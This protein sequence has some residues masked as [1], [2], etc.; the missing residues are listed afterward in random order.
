MNLTKKLASALVAVAMTLTCLPALAE[1][2]TVTRAQ[3]VNSF[4]EAVGVE[5]LTPVG[6]SP[7]SFNDWDE[8]PEE[9]RANM[10]LAVESGLILGCDGKLSPNAELTRL[11]AVI[12]L[13]RCL[14]ELTEIRETVAFTDVPDWAE[15]E[16]ARLYR[17]GIVNGY[18]EGLMGSYDLINGEQLKL[19]TDRAGSAAYGNVSLKDDFYAA[20]NRDYFATTRIGEGRPKLSI[21]SVRGDE[22]SDW[23]VTRS[24]ELLERLNAG[25]E[26]KPVEER[27][28]RFY[29]LALKT[30]EEAEPLAPLNKYFE[31]IDACSGVLDFGNVNGVIIRDLSVPVLFG[32]TLP[33]RFDHD[34]YI[35]ALGGIYID[36]LDTG[37][38]RSYWAEDADGVEAAYAEYTGR[39]LNLVGVRDS[40]ALA[41]AIAA[42]QR[43]VALA[44]KSMAQSMSDEDE[45]LQL[46]F[47]WNELCSMY[48]GRWQNPIPSTLFAIDSRELTGLSDYVIS[49][50][51]AADKAVELINSADP[52]ALKALCKLNLV[53]GLIDFLPEEFRTARYELEAEV[54]GWETAL[55]RERHAAMLAS[56]FFSAAYETEFINTQ[57]NYSADQLYEMTDIIITKFENMFENSSAISENT[58]HA[59]TEKL[60]KMHRTV[61]GYS[62][63]NGRNEDYPKVREEEGLVGNAIAMMESVSGGYLSVLEFA[64]TAMPGYTVNASYSPY[65]NSI[66]IYGG[67]LFD[68][69]YNPDVSYEENLAGIGFTIAH[70]IS[71]AF[72]GTGSLYD[73]GGNFA[74]WWDEEDYP[75]FEEFVERLKTYYSRYSNEYGDPVDSALTGDENFADIL[76]MECI[77]SIAKENNLDLDRI[78]RAY[79]RSWASVSTPA[80]AQYLSRIDTH[81]PDC[82]RV[83]AVLSNFDEFYETYGVTEGDGMYVPPEERV[84][85]FNTNT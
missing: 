5:S 57:V 33:C 36:W 14:P 12:I 32:V 61:A 15:D 56:M 47:D 17:A 6:G 30:G 46:L 24:E 31:K 11:E 64:D 23:L 41:Q 84:H 45:G 44:G 83:N 7:E 18:G 37:I 26:L 59:A 21:T 76:A 71:H 62:S 68:P 42:I 51:G 25:E 79:A 28:A 53:E 52:E 8:V 77:I 85:L 38:D 43:E 66:E 58:R 19:L 20:V 2:D 29:A 22:I 73:A 60:R 13:G 9:Y 54:M 82:V 65:L 49:D 67:V 50:R 55:D 70:E 39:I 1:V 34:G 72:D 74:P 35:E 69:L 3:A 27:A 10:A 75:I 80:Y 48:S 16:I 81:S 40:Q 78:F 63:D 4:V